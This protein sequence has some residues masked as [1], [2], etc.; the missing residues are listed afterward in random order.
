MEFVDMGSGNVLVAHCMAGA[1][2]DDAIKAATDFCKKF[3]V[4]CVVVHHNRDLIQ[5]DRY[6]YAPIAPGEMNEA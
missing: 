3:D 5:V 1:D 6:G 4:R 2:V